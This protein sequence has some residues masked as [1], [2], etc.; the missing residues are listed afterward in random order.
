MSVLSLL[1]L[2]IWVALLSR[3]AWLVLHPPHRRAYPADRAIAG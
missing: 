1:S 2:V 3:A